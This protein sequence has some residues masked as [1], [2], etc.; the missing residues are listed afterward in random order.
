MAVIHAVSSIEQ[1]ALLV[2]LGNP[3]HSVKDYTSSIGNMSSVERAGSGCYICCVSSIEQTPISV[4]LGTCP[5][6]SGPAMAV[7]HTESSV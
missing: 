2:V 4:P 6:W 5:T 1:A 3:Q 7:K